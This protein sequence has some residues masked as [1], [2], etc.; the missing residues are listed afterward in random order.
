MNSELRKLCRSTRAATYDHDI[1]KWIVDIKTA[2]NTGKLVLDKHT[3]S[4]Y[5][6]CC[7]YCIIGCSANYVF[8]SKT[9]CANFAK[10]IGTEYDGQERFT[11]NISAD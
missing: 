7:I 9:L 1:K 6:Y 3:I 4:Y 11:D 8:G 10:S 5:I 2:H